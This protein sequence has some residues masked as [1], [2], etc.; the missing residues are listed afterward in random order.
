LLAAGRQQLLFG[1]CEAA[2][3]MKGV[4]QASSLQRHLAM[5]RL[6]CGGVRLSEAVSLCKNV[7][8]VEFRCAAASEAYT[9]TPDWL[10]IA[11][12]ARRTRVVAY[13]CCWWF[14]ALILRD[15]SLTHAGGYQL[16]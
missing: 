8:L 2:V 7:C 13:V 16:V 14:A 5:R 10:R 11:C 6:A 12:W 9:P 4:D 3:G 15:G 1:Q